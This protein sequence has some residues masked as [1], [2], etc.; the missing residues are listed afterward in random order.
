MTRA[1]SPRR[2]AISV[3]ALL[4]G[5]GLAG[6][7]LTGCAAAAA[8]QAA[9]TARPATTSPAPAASSTAPAASSPSAH[10]TPVTSR[11]GPPAALPVAPG[12]GPQPQTRTLPSTDSVAFRHAMTDLWLAVTTGNARLALPAFF[13]LA[14]Y[15]QLK[16]LYDPSTDWHDRLWY[17][18]TLD[19]GAAHRLVGRGAHLVRVVVPTVDAAWIY[20]GGCDNKLG[21][22]HV[23]ES[24]VVYVQ[25]GQERSFG[26]ASL[27]SWRGVWYVVH[28][29]AVLR[30]VVTGLVDQPETGPGVPGP[31]GGC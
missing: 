12:A 17:D 27:I 25:G 2:A 19:V 8:P 26:I 23:P 10:P 20:P 15:Q 18:F 1:R 16:A 30:D 28:F 22:W 11:T 5:C 9:K 24:R 31:A 29:G 13:P 4:A 7:A 6:G 3:A 14:A 21:Y